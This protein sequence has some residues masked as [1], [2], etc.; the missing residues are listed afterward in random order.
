MNWKNDVRVRIRNFK[1]DY[2]PSQ[3]ITVY[4]GFFSVVENGFL[5][6]PTKLL[7]NC[8]ADDVESGRIMVYILFSVWAEKKAVLFCILNMKIFKIGE[9][10]RWVKVC[11][12]KKKVAAGAEISMLL[13]KVFVKYMTWN[14]ESGQQ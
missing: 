2:L 7:C 4:P 10:K 9:S 11:Q 6:G 8:F 14:F 3:A 5:I 12:R 13:K 1:K